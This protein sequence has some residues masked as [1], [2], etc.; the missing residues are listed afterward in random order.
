MNME[1]MSFWQLFLNNP[2]WSLVI[3]G[4]LT[5]FFIGWQALET[6]RAAEASKQSIGVMERQTKAAEDAAHAA[7][8]SADALI[9]SERAWVM[10][11]LSPRVRK[12]GQWWYREDNVAITEEEVLAGKYL[13]YRLMI[14]NMGRTPAQIF[15]YEM[16]SGSLQVGTEFSVDKLSTMTV[17]NVNFFLGS[18]KPQTLREF[19]IDDVFEKSDGTTNGTETGAIFVRIRYA[20]VVSQG[21]AQDIRE[22]SFMYYY[23]AVAYSLDRISAENRYT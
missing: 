11:E 12:V 6:R 21:R 19:T 10:G 8:V 1:P 9:A 22:T 5:M 7:K 18:D 16:R 17:H 15:S 3:V 4:I 2:E 23:R 20:D 13:S 14:V